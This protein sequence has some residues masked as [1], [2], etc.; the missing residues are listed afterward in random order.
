MLK[1]KFQKDGKCFDLVDVQSE[2]PQKALRTIY[3]SDTESRVFCCCHGHEKE[4][5]LVIALRR[6]TGKFELRKMP[7]QKASMH[8][9]E[10]FFSRERESSDAIPS[11]NKSHDFYLIFPT[12]ENRWFIDLKGLNNLNKALHKMIHEE[13]EIKNWYHLKSEMIELS[14]KIKLN[15]EILAKSLNIIT[16]STKENLKPIWFRGEETRLLFGECLYVNYIK[17]SDSLALKLK[18]CSETIWYKKSR[19]P[20]R[21]RGAITSLS[22]NKKHYILTMVRRSVSGKYIQGYGISLKSELKEIKQESK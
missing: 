17:D 15:D 1:V 19:L 12:S 3:E 21:L 20:G 4:L 11:P 13:I 2:S 22:A 7:G 8:T 9:E 16:P 18:G 10:C 5:P 14:K 6:K